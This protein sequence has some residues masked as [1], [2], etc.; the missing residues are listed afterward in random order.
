MACI[1]AA[2]L[3]ISPA[4]PAQS[5][6]RATPDDT[7]R[8]LAGLRPS[9]ASPLNAL[10]KSAVWQTHAA[11]FNAAFG[12][13]DTGSLSKIRVFGTKEILAIRPAAALEF[14]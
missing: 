6:E 8:F 14:F 4:L 13:K 3:L 1:F 11:R 9:P 12:L 5:T 2:V 7:A 10:T